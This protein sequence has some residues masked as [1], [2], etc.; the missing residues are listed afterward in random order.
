MDMSDRS[1]LEKLK[2]ITQ[3]RVLKETYIEEMN[4]QGVILE[5][6]K[7]GARIFLMSNDDDNKVFCIGFR[8]PPEDSSGLPHILE[9][10][11]LEGSEKFPVKDPFVELVK[12]SL[13]TFLNAMTYPD[14]TVY[15]V[16]SCNDKD[17]RN[18]MDVYMDGVLHPRIYREPKIFLQEGWHYEMESPEDDLTINGVV[19]NEMKGAFS[20]PES[21][22]DRYTRAVLFPDNSYANESGGDPAFIPELTY[23]QFIRF[24]Q[25]YYHPANSYI[26]LYGDMD[27]E[28]N[29][30][31]L[32]EQYLS[33]YDRKDCP[34]DSSIPLQ[35]PFTEPVQREI[36]YSVTPEEGTEKKTYLSVNTVV[37]TDL[38]PKLYVAF[39][40]LEYALISAPAAPLKQALIDA[41]LGEDIMGGYESG[42][43]QP[44]FSVIAKNADKEQKA[45]FLIAVKGTLRRLADQGIDRKSLLAGLNYYEFRYREADYGSAPKGLMYGLWSMDS[46]LYDGDPLM[47]LEYQETFD[48]LKQAVDQ[49]YFE[50][51]IR[52][53]LLDNPHEAVILVTPEPGKTEREDE[54][55]ANMLAERKASMTPEAIEA[56][57]RGTRELREYQEEPSS[58]EDLEKIPMLGRED[59]SRQGAQLQYTVKE[60]AGVTVL[61]TDLF[62][63]GI[64][65]LKILFNTD[66]VPVEDL[67]YVGLLKAVLGYVDTEQHTYGDLSSEIFLNSGG[68]DFSVTSFVDLENRG[69]FTGAFVVN[70]KV[71]YE[72]LDFVFHTVTEILTRSKLDNE[73]RLGEI[74]D[75]VR[76]R[77]RMRLD[78]SA[79]AAAVS[80]ASSYFSPTSAFNEM[81]GGIGYYHFL[82][83]VA[84]RY[85]SEPGYRKELIAKLKETIGRL[86]TADNLLVGYTAD[87]E[88]YAVLRR[89]LGDFKA[90]LPAGDQARYP[91]AFEPGNRNEGF[92]TASQVNYVA[93]CGS[94]AGSGYAYTGALKVLKVIMNY[95]YLWSNLRVEGG[96]YGCMSS[97]GASMEGYFVSY[98]DPNLANTN[99]VYEGIPEYLRNFSIEERDMTKYVIGTISDID[100]PMSPAVRGSRS[101]SAYLS[102]V[103]D[104]MIQKER[105]EVLD[106][107]QEDI[108]GLAGIIQAVLD[109]G[110]LCVVGNGQKIRE[111]EALFKNIQ[112][113]YH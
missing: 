66:R 28:E 89:E 94:F 101:V 57:V 45:E 104:E 49:G 63:S 85:G 71:L 90:S 58:Q 3:Y 95:E 26:Y 50:G 21:V 53:Y 64:G 1:N 113:L 9:H 36:T 19:Y 54:Q 25:T 59:I 8:T 78:D 109:T 5:H 82:E 29:L 70:A 65:Y 72:K 103:T 10:S 81:V 47:H 14:K 13:N 61:H 107:T 108:R 97:V 79:H 11:V 37:G 98:R 88:G 76:S 4:S 40:I 27:M 39:Q 93:R 55:L 18:L 22:L 23:E 92:M 24:H 80:R 110:A 106:V 46:W 48:F 105:E 44:Y 41:G 6:V 17:F 30:R 62:T 34:V 83:D 20:S 15:P 2:D 51:L 38:D 16:A 99:A 74:L 12:G 73:K 111:D 77:S 96:A 75:E 43:L 33:R 35:K 84:K 100:A 102:H 68:L 52:Q 60:E 32:D 112:N 31:W 87:Q 42:I 56:V 7:S 91:F 86:F 69:Q 67:P